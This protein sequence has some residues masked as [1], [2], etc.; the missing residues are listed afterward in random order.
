MVEPA[1]F[2]YY[3]DEK[4]EDNRGM[5]ILQV[6]IAEYASEVMF[7]LVGV[8]GWVVGVVYNKKDR[9]KPY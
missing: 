9:R 4:A 1:Q 7:V 8:G 3:N 2:D 5:D 6:R